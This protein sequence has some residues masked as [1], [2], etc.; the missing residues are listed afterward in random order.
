MAL[1]QNGW[2]ASANKRD[3]D[4]DPNFAVAGVKFP[5]GV[6]AGDVS[7]VLR[8][9][10]EQF[11][12][13]VEPLRDGW[14]WGYAYRDIRGSTGLSNHSAACAIDVNAPNHP[15]GKRGTFNAAQVAR[16]RLIVQA[17]GGVVAWGG[18]WSR[19]DE[20]HFEIVGSAAAVAAVA[21]RIRRTGGTDPTPAPTPTGGN[22]QRGS[23]GDR[24]K[25][26]QRVLNAWYPNLRLVTDGIFG[27]ATEKA[28][29]D[30]Q[31]RAGL[32]VDGIAGPAT[33][34]RLGLA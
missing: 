9:V 31:A 26:L 22:L 18:E 10:A 6:K 23:T 25:T 8:Y 4:V 3:I 12:A 7:T 30:M 5:G 2:A 34:G 16:I 14:C 19:P 15:L 28:V 27:P 33:L 29:R 21:D 24:V 32:A 17:C 20:M 13:H 11:H 1:A